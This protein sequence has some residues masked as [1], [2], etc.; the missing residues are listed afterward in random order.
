MIVESGFRGCDGKGRHG[1]ELG[2]IVWNPQAGVGG[3]FMMAIPN[4]L[5][6]PPICYI[7]SLD[8][9]CGPPTTNPGPIA[10]TIITAA[11]VTTFPCPGSTCIIPPGPGAYSQDFQGQSYIPGPWMGCS[12]S[13]GTGPWP[14]A[15]VL[16]LE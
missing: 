16:R 2:Q 13:T 14:L 15:R 10:T 4:V 6:N 9:L 12:L 3:A 1:P 11:N 8:N 7:A 5:N